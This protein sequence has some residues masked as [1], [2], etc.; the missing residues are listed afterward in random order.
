MHPITVYGIETTATEPPATARCCMHP[1]TV[2]G[3]ETL[4][5]AS[6]FYVIVA[7]TLLP[8]TVLKLHGE[9][10]INNAILK[11]HAPYYRLR[12]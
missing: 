6:L 3:I 5:H 4:Y 7:C 1:I 12:Y 10:A 11:L 2:Y 9:I 8:F